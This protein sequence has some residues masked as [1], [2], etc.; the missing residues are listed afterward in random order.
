MECCRTVASGSEKV[1]YAALPQIKRVFIEAQ[2]RHA[3]AADPD[4]F[5]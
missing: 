4:R 3:S 2:E 1:I 5:G